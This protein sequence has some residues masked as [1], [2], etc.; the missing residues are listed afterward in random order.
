[1]AVDYFPSLSL[2]SFW[3]VTFNVV[4]KPENKEYI[5]QHGDNYIF[6]IS[7]TSLNDRQQCDRLP[8]SITGDQSWS[9]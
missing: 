8:V 4:T 2:W 6:K 7:F 9:R 3:C 1:M 5:K